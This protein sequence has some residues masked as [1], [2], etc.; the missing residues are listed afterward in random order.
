[1]LGWISELSMRSAV[2]IIEIKD[3]LFLSGLESN[4]KQRQRCSYASFC[5]QKY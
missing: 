1:M 4:L 2:D 5:V 3:S